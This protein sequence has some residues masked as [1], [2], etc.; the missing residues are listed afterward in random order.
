MPAP[1]AIP[2]HAA[3]I[4]LVEIL[5]VVGVILVLGF[6]VFDAYRGVKAK[7][8]AVSEQRTVS[9]VLGMAQ[10]IGKGNYRGLD[11]VGL[12]REGGIPPALSGGDRNATQ[13]ENQWGGAVAI[14]PTGSGTEP[15]AADSAVCPG[16]SFEYQQV[17][18]AVC[19]A[20]VPFLRMSFRNLQVLEGDGA[21]MTIQRAQPAIAYSF[22]RMIEG[23]NQARRLTLVM[24]T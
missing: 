24:T 10:R 12:N 17:P 5:F 16:L 21:T 11:A 4:A 15:C 19:L 13:L 9:Y 1:R 14:T 6:V 7:Q 3:G 2:R 8:E 22:E 18:Q 20:W 23:C